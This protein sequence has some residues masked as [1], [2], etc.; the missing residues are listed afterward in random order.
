[1]RLY[2]RDD[3]PFCWKSRIAFAF[4]E[5]APDLIAVGRGE[6]HPDIEKLSSTLTIPV[7]VEGDLVITQSGVLVEYINDA[8]AAGK[9]LPTSANNRAIARNLNAYSDM[10]V[11]KALKGLVFERRDKTKE[12]RDQSLIS[13]SEK[14]WR[15]CLDYL[16]TII[17]GPFMLGDFSI[18]DCALLPRFALASRYDAGVDDEHPVLLEYWKRA[19]S[20]APF[21][22]SS[23]N[24]QP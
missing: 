10:V 7:F 16:E 2:H 3:C 24:A 17:K 6:K 22:S 4:A 5:V 9:L 19:Q 13:A 14:D 1:M 15:K 11:G 21:V 8:Y 23:S 18:A 12:G 20:F